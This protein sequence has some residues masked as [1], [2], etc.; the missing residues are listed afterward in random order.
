MLKHVNKNFIS[1]YTTLRQVNYKD[2][3]KRKGS[4]LFRFSNLS[5]DY[6]L[7]K[8]GNL[9]FIGVFEHNLKHKT[10]GDLID[11]IHDFDE[12][13]KIE[14]ETD[15]DPK[16]L[17]S[18]PANYVLDFNTEMFRL[19]DIIHSPLRKTS[20]KFHTDD[21]G[22]TF[23]LYTY[24]AY[25]QFSKKAVDTEEVGDDIEFLSS[26]SDSKIELRYKATSLNIFISPET[27][28]KLWGE[29]GLSLFEGII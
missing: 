25:K 22:N 3:T 5:P 20:V 12:N 8:V 4:L 26:I 28:L 2:H 9:L 23:E 11:I 29:E 24:R 14:I 27:P 16:A 18:I 6:K 10:L 17:D 21:L 13:I 19:F 15:I 7:K 1:S